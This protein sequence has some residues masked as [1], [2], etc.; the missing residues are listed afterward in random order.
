LA[1]AAR[2]ASAKAITINSLRAI[3][4]SFPNPISIKLRE[5]FADHLPAIAQTTP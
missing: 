5:T 4:R 1:E 2:V 3:E